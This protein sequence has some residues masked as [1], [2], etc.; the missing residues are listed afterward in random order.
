MKAKLTIL[1]VF[2]M[3]GTKAQIINAYADVTALSGQTITLASVDEASDTFED[4]EAVILMQMQDDCIGSNTTNVVTFGNLGSIA[5]AGVYEVAYISSHTESAGLPVTLVVSSALNNTYSIGAASR[6][7]VISF[8]LFGSPNFTTAGNYVAKAWN[9]T[10]GGLLA[11]QVN[12][13][14]TLS[15]NLSANG[16]GFRGGA[17]SANYY[18]GGSGCSTTEYIRT[19]NHTRAGRK[20]EGIYRTSNN[21]FLYARGKLLNGGGGGSERINCGGGGGGNFTDGGLGGVGWSCAGPG[22]GGLGGLSLSGQI[23]AFRIFMG[24][25]GGGGQQNDSQGSAGG[26]GGGIV[27]IKASAIVTSG[28]CGGR[29]ISANGNSVTGLT[30]DGQG[31]GGAGGSI[32]L[33]VGTWGLAAGC[34]LTVSANGGNGGTANTSTHAGGGGGGQGVVIYSS[35]QPTSNVSTL[36]NNGTPGCNNNSSPCTNLAGAPSGSNGSGVFSG[37]NNPLP[38]EWSKFYLERNNLSVSIYWE[39]QS[40]KNNLYF[41]IQRSVNAEDWKTLARVHGANNSA[42]K[43]QYEFLDKNAP[44]ELAY[45]RLKQVDNNESFSFSTILFVD[46]IETHGTDVLIFPNP[47][48]EHLTLKISSEEIIRISQLEIYNSNGQ[49]IYEHPKSLLQDAFQDKEMSVVQKLEPGI[50]TC[51]V[52]LGEKV[53]RVK[54]FVPN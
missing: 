27:L 53:M 6:L 36:T 35:A 20:G 46:A 17:A 47:I 43:R 13:T 7:Q 40:E 34:Q 54:F 18:S 26:N 41:E 37:L 15:N 9:G 49:K 14:L 30:N 19:T 16:C 52:V 45:Y 28:A 5:A 10:T 4:G 25:G 1:L 31:G 29:S 2:I 21:N 8:P 3:I 22:G 32:V 38:I 24:G 12:G 50:Y 23:S 48:E 11:F 39:T 33:E 42:I 51:L 44:T